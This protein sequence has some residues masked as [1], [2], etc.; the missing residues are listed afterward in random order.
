MRDPLIDA[1]VIR[2]AQQKVHAAG[3]VASIARLF[4]EEPELYFVVSAHAVAALGDLDGVTREMRI[5]AHHNVWLAA[6]TALECYRL[7]YYQLW[8]RTEVG[9]ALEQAEPSIAQAP[10]CP[11]SETDEGAGGGSDRR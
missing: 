1:T 3:P 7:A 10:P 2:S 8:R 6:L 11:Q 4:E 5:K 9:S